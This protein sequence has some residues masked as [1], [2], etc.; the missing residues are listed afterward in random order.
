MSAMSRR[1]IFWGVFGILLIAGLVYAFLPQPIPVDLGTVTVGPMRITI[2]D[3]GKTRVRDVY[4]VSAP[5]AGR[6]MRITHKVGD[7]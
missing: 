5:L 7:R 4:T 1:I 3:E 2:N 6:S